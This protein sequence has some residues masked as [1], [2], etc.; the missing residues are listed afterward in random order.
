MSIWHKFLLLSWAFESISKIS[1]TVDG[2]A[3][4]NIDNFLNKL[5]GALTNTNFAIFLFII[6]RLKAI[7]VYID[8]EDKETILWKLRKVNSIAV[9][10]GICYMMIMSFR[11]LLFCAEDIDVWSEQYRV[12]WWY[13]LVCIVNLVVSL[14]G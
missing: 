4:N 11:M 9:M 1:V 6:Y 2:I 14:A 10:F 12:A 8:Y 13:L 7:E 5:V 3:Q